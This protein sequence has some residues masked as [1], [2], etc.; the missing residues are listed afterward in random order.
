MFISSSLPSLLSLLWARRL[1]LC[2]LHNIVTISFSSV[3]SPCPFPVWLSCWFWSSRLWFPAES[4][5]LDL[6]C[7]WTSFEIMPLLFQ[8]V[9]TSGHPASWESKRVSRGRPLLKHE[10]ASWFLRSLAV[11]L[12]GRKPASKNVQRTG[13][14]F[15]QTTESFRRFGGIPC[16]YFVER[17]IIWIWLIL[18][19]WI[20]GL[21]RGISQR[22]LGK[23]ALFT[24]ILYQ[25]VCGSEPP[26]CACGQHGRWVQHHETLTNGK[27]RQVFNEIADQMNAGCLK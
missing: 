19:S 15:S 11:D 23:A 8:P 6:V 27:A 17:L 7:I 1:A 20:R 25:G 3:F 18:G 22:P 21:G 24:G 13:V 14:P 5:M 26:V 10:S 4:R 2:S 16:L 9:L 12:F